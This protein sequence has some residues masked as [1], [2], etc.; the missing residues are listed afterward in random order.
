[1]VQRLEKS[2]LICVFYIN[3]SILP[4]FILARQG[5]QRINLDIGKIGEKIKHVRSLIS[6]LLL[7]QVLKLGLDPGAQSKA[8]NCILQ[9]S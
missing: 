7:N 5:L 6:Q 3:V 1:M 2:Y 9:E 8:S 4:I